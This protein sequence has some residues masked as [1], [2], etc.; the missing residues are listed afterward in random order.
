[1]RVVNTGNTYRIYNNSLKTFDQLPAQAYSVCFHPQQGFWL[2]KF[3]DLEVNEKIY[4]VHMAKVE[5]VFNSFKVFSRNLGIILSGDKGIGKSLGNEIAP[6]RLNAK[7]A[8]IANKYTAEEATIKAFEAGA[9]IIYDPADFV[10]SYTA[11]LN[12][13]LRSVNAGNSLDKS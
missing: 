7:T 9:D 10:K 6:N 11:L 4:G 12:A 5:K 2:E 1:M 13:V 3:S 8:N